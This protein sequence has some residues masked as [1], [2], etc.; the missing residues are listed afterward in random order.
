MKK[1]KIQRE[2]LYNMKDIDII[3]IIEKS[4]YRNIFEIWKKAEK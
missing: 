4:K 1:E 3:N 2:D